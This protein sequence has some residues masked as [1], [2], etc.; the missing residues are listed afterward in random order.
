[1][2]ACR[3]LSVVGRVGLAGLA[4]LTISLSARVGAT[5]ADVGAAIG[6]GA[7]LG[8]GAAAALGAA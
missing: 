3:R 8:F 5:D 7:F 4:R 6:G 1:M 2:N